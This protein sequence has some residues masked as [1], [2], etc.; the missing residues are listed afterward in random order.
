MFLCVLYCSEHLL[1]FTYMTL[2]TVGDQDLCDFFFSID[3][4]MNRQVR[5][6][7]FFFKTDNFYNKIDP[8]FILADSL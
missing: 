1:T 4:C 5:Q 8:F 3:N 2:Y 6:H 7:L